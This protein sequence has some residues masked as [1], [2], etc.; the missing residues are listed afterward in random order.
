M[1][2]LWYRQPAK[3]WEEALPLGNGRMGA[4]VFGGVEQER[5]QVNEESVWYGG[6]TDRINPDARRYLEEI[7]RRIFAGEIAGAQELLQMAWRV[8][9]TACAHTRLWGISGWNF[10]ARQSMSSMSEVCILRM[11]C[12]GLPL[13][14]AEPDIS[15][16]RFFP[17]LTTVW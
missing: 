7:R 15:G 2:R 1:S 12:A 16:R 10:P 11:L 17:I 14:A 13:S 4:M 8:V 3:E 6:E 5:I 9:L